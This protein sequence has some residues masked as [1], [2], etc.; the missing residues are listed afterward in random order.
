M[1]LDEFSSPNG[2]LDEAALARIDHDKKDKNL[3]DAKFKAK[4]GYTRAEME[5][6]TTTKPAKKKVKEATGDLKFD[7]MLGKISGNTK[8]QDFN[9][10]RANKV[11]AG[12]ENPDKETIDAL[13]KMMYDMHVTMMTANELMKKL[14][15]GR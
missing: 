10:D 12:A 5:S 1:N 15:Q 11:Q 9:Q 4:Y 6:R 3:S 2:K 7:N 8:P 14:T 13:N